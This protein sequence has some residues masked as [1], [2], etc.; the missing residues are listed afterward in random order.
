[1]AT[2]RTIITAATAIP[3]IL[4]CFM[5]RLSLSPKKP[6]ALATRGRV[7]EAICSR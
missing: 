7:S 5:E 1:M 4:S 3:I 2:K 6:G